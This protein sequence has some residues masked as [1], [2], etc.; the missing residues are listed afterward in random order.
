MGR[1]EFKE[2]YVNSKGGVKVL[3]QIPCELDEE[4]NEWLMTD[5]GDS[6]VSFVKEQMN[7]EEREY[8]EVKSFQANQV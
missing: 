5:E 1:F 3:I 8:G 7:K 2:F 4:L 6:I